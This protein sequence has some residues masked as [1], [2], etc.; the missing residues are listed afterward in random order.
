MYFLLIIMLFFSFPKHV[1]F[2]ILY[3][4]FVPIEMGSPI[5]N[6]PIFVFKMELGLYDLTIND[7]VNISGK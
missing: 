4:Y 5:V 6:F 7:K 3:K 1:T 2:F